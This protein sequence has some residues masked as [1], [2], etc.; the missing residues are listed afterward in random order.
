ME[1]DKNTGMLVIIGIC[2]LV[3]FMGLL[4]QKAEFLLNF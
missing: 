2:L 1:M 3:L 4:R